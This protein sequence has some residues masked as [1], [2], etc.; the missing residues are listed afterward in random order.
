MPTGPVL[1]FDKSTLQS[2]NPDESVWLDNFF[3]T[4]ITPLFFVE[5]LADLEKE[6][7]SGRT[8]EQVVGE[9]AYKTPD[10]GSRPNVHHATLVA[11]ELMGATTVP[12]RG[13]PII[14]GGQPV[15]LGGKKGVIFREAPE[16]EALSRWQ[17]GEFLDIE[18]NIAKTWRRALSD[19]DFEESYKSFQRFFKG[20]KKPGNLGEVKIFADQVIDSVDQTSSLILGMNL[21]G[22]SQEW[23]SHILERWSKS[24]VKT[25]R[26]FAPYFRHVFSVD[27]F[28][29]LALA[30]DLVSRNRPSHKVDI[31]Y[32]YYLPF[33]MVFSSS[34]K[35]HV[36]T[37]TL[38]TNL[39][40][41][42]V[43]GAD[44][45]TD[46]AKLDKH[47][48]SLPEEV[49]SRGLFA[50][51]GYPPTDQSFLVTQLWDKY[52]TAWRRHASEHREPLSKELQGA[53]LKLIDKFQN[54]STPLDPATPVSQE[55]IEQMTIQRRVLPRKGKWKRF[56]PEVENAQKRK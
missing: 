27:L 26:E 51:A 1:I 53:L 24:A 25:I 43:T 19:I 31:A 32:L 10:M 28:F 21:L 23:Q 41:T 38:F 48:S 7:R 34:D 9:L 37:A 55:E 46:F 39:G 11:G 42:F 40:Q 17:R 8:P 45:K 44:L 16:E 30:A 22:V 3:L 2:L 54:E 35:L 15:E 49:K 5:T 29:Y 56:P 33:C 52:F 18:R 13:L 50:F 47:Y 6:M 20:K 4:N 36:R 14:S 12:M